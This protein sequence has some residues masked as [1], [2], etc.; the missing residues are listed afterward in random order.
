MLNEAP[1][2]DEIRSLIDALHSHAS[3]L[4]SRREIE[5]AN[6]FDKD[7]AKKVQKLKLGY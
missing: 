6:Y 1:G 5:F 7:L 3:A 2:S 4:R